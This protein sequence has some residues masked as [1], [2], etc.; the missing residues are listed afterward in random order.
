[1]ASGVVVLT[2]E[3]IAPL[4]I[5]LIYGAG[6]APSVGPARVLLLSVL[7]WALYWPYAN[8][9]NAAH[10]EKRIRFL[11]GLGLVID[12]IL[13]WTVGGHFGAIG[14]AWA[15][16]ISESFILGGL[17]LSSRKLAG[18]WETAQQLLKGGH[19]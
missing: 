11:V 19:G 6:F 7:P 17:A 8:A 10:R 16:V 15:W 4:L 5:R 13:V 12:F 3:I 1:M 18:Q 14:A 2:L 9:L